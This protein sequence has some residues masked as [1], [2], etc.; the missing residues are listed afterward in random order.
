MFWFR[1]RATIRSRVRSRTRDI[2]IA[3]VASA[4]GTEEPIRG[5]LGVFVSCGGSLE[6]G[7][8][9]EFWE[10]T[11]WEGC[12]EDTGCSVGVAAYMAVAEVDWQGQGRRGESDGEMDGFAETLCCE[13]YVC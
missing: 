7:W 3:N 12:V 2:P 9:D 6:G 1:L 4:G 10:D 11:L 8:Q 13:G 5:C